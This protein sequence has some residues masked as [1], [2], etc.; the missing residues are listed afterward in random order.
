[1]SLFRPRNLV[2][3]A[4]VLLNLLLLG[5]LALDRFNSPSRKLGILTRDIAAASIVDTGHIPFSLP[6]GL[7]VRDESPRGLAAAGM[8]EPYR[9]SIVIT[10]DDPEAVSYAEASRDLNQVGEL[11]SMDWDKGSSYVPTTPQAK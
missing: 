5:Y 3:A 11:Y 10:T 9:F 1:M 4:S 8:F 7:T 2:L 6:K